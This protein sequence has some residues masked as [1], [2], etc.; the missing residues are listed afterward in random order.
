LLVAKFES[1]GLYGLFPSY[2]WN[3]AGSSD[4]DFSISQLQLFL[5]FLLGGG[6]NTG[7]VPIMNYDWKANDATIPLNLAV[8]RTVKAGNTPIKLEVEI[9]YYIEQPDA[10]GPEWMIGLNITPV[11]PN[12]V[13]GWIKRR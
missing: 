8:G 9:N 2:Q 10:F 3:I 12:I 11:V 1:W 6:W 4:E 7:S 13:E 5:K